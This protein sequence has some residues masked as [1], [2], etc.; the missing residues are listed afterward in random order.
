MPTFPDFIFED[1]HIQTMSEALCVVCGRLALSGHLGDRAT[2]H[3]ARRII[4]FA[5]N[6]ER[7]ADR[8]TART[9]ADFG[10]ENDGW[11]WRH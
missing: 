4:E 1:E 8:L 6:G 2:E 5:R 10:I 11:L 7:N 9:L 3:V